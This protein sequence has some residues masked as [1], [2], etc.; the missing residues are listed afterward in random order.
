MPLNFKPNP[1]LASDMFGLDCWYSIAGAMEY[2]IWR[3]PPDDLGP[4][5]FRVNKAPYEPA[6]PLDG[7]YRNVGDTYSFAL[8]VELAETDAKEALS[9]RK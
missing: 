6:K 7:A 8:A 4:E 3:I 9:E 1:G 5:T 2:V